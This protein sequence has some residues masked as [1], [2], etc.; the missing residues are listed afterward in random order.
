MNT[1]W[2]GIRPTMMIA[3]MGVFVVSSTG[4]VSSTSYKAVEKEASNAQR[5]YDEE[6]LRALELEAKNNELAQRME[7]W[8][9]T[10]RNTMNRLERLA[11]D[12]GEVR[13]DLIRQNL[14][15]ELQR[16][17]RQGKMAEG[18]ILLQR[19]RRSP[20]TDE[21]AQV[22]PQVSSA[23]AKDRAKGLMKQSRGVLEQY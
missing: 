11:N 23:E 21:V 2:R 8:D 1:R 17:K 3:L 12:W 10:L 19:K 4:C 7:V 14:D 6:H 20:G 16:M 13:D 22:E 5:M 9:A 18:T 15:R